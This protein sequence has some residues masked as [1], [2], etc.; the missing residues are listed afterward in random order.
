[1]L[2]AEIEQETRVVARKPRRVIYS[3]PILPRISGWSPWNRW[4]LLC[5]PI[6]KTLG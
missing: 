6:S 3:T 2:P 1:M 4:V 5:H